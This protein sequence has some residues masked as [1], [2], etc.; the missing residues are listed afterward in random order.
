[1]KRGLQF[2][3]QA[4]LASAPL[5]LTLLVL[6]STGVLTQP[7]PAI[8]T[9]LATALI[10]EP[11]RSALSRSALADQQRVVFCGQ[12]MVALQDVNEAVNGLILNYHPAWNPRPKD[13]EKARL[14]QAADRLVPIIGLAKAW[15]PATAGPLEALASE[16]R[17]AVEFSHRKWE[18]PMDAYPLP[19]KALTSAWGAVNRLRNELAA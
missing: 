17:D 7:A 12:A 6:Y 13:N 11:V 1:M 8:V 10:L 15:A 19:Q 16:V 2:T 14:L 9:A 4:F 3:T 5:V 18:S